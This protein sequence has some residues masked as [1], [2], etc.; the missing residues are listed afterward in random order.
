MLQSYP[1]RLVDHAARA[2]SLGAL[3]CI[4]TEPAIE[5]AKLILSLP[6][7]SDPSDNPHYCYN[8]INGHLLPLADLFWPCVSSIAT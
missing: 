7:L 8:Q 1:P 3:F 5:A 6:S 4:S 2:D